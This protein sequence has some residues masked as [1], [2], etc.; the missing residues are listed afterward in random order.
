M[1]MRSASALIA[2]DGPVIIVVPVSIAA[3]HGL[4]R[5]TADGQLVD[6]EPHPGLEE[7]RRILG[8][9]ADCERGLL[10]EIWAFCGIHKK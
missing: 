3:V 6:R 4:V 10:F 2:S 7:A 5:R 8:E 9:L 1:G